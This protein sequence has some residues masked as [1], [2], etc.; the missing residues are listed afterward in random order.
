M[1]QNF[2]THGQ[3]PYRVVTVHGGP[4]ASRSM[5]PV[6]ARISKTKGVI[7]Y[8][9][10]KSTIEGLKCE[11][12]DIVDDQCNSPLTLIGHSWGA[13]LSII[14]A[15][16]Y[17]E[18][19][20]KLILVNSGPFEEIYAKN[21]MPK[22]LERLTSEEMKEFINL[23][24]KLKNKKI[25][26]KNQV[27]YQLGNFIH[28]VDS[29]LPIDQ[30][31]KEKCRY[32]YHAFREIWPEASL[33]RQSGELL[34]IAKKVTCPVIAIHG[35]YDPHPAK[36]VNEPLKRV[37]KDFQF[38]LLVKCGHTPW[39]ELYAKEEFYRIVSEELND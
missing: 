4:G 23:S 38:V 39:E 9:Q 5:Q 1:E 8:V 32:N 11:L 15:A 28:K 24:E 14:F 17:P 6:A 36:G 25:S 16:A 27:F 37:I 19:I 26:N 3:P 33:L 2:F 12:L 20:K 31:I 34:K 13:W 10:Q 21:I 29:Y 35:D 22:R 7:E 30:Q 18:K